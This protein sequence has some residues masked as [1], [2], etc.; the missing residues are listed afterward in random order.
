MDGDVQAGPAADRLWYP[1]LDAAEAW[2][3][4]PCRDFSRP[5]MSDNVGR[6]SDIGTANGDAILTARAGAAAY[7]ACGFHH[8]PGALMNTKIL[9]PLCVA[10]A[11]L[12]ACN[13]H[14]NTDTSTDTATTPSTTAAPADTAPP[15]ADAT[16]PP[17]ETPP[18]TDTPPPAD[19]QPSN[20]PPSGNK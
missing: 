20:P 14:K 17:G 9:I 16:P 1:T 8:F 11:L 2:L 18:A 19:T 6:E 5:G 10:S 15:P 13:Q 3:M 12:A 4:T 7:G